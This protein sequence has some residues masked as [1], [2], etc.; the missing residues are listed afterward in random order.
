MRALVIPVSEKDK[1]YFVT[2]D[3]QELKTY[4]KEIGCSCID[5]CALGYNGRYVL[6][7]AVDDC[8]LLNGSPLNERFDR[9]YRNGDANST[10][11][12]VAVISMSDLLTGDTVDLDE[13]FVISVLC[14]DL[15]FD[16]NDFIDLEW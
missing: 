7:A 11:A 4:Y 8:G 6:E 14:N 1:P 13:D 10:L 9:V 16:I 12:G 2:I 5:F 3:D 15:G